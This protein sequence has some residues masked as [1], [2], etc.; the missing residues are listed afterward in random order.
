M[1]ESQFQRFCAP[2]RPLDLTPSN[3][4]YGGFAHY[5]SRLSA[6]TEKESHVFLLP[7]FNFKSAYIPLNSKEN[8]LIAKKVLT[9]RMDYLGQNVGPLSSLLVYFLDDERNEAV[10]NIQFEQNDLIEWFPVVESVLFK[11]AMVSLESAISIVVHCNQVNKGELQICHYH[12]VYVDEAEMNVSPGDMRMRTIN[13]VSH[14]YIQHFL[15]YF[16]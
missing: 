5:L 9:E 10:D 3:N 15:K 6:V 13:S 4:S 1:A 16:K 12:I 8:K 2:C 14:S 7:S 11:S